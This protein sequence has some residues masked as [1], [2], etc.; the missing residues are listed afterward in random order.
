M[1]TQQDSSLTGTIFGS[2][3]AFPPFFF[4]PLPPSFPFAPLSPFGLPP[5]QRE[6]K[7]AVTHA[8][9]FIHRVTISSSTEFTQWVLVSGGKLTRW[10]V[11]S[12]TK[13][14][15]LSSYTET[16]IAKFTPISCGDIIHW[17]KTSKEDWLLI[18]APTHMHTLTSRTIILSPQ[19]QTLKLHTDFKTGHEVCIPPASHS[20]STFTVLNVD[21][22]ET[23]HLFPSQYY[24]RLK[25]ILTTRDTTEGLKSKS[26]SCALG[27]QGYRWSQLTFHSLNSGFLDTNHTHAADMI[28]SI[29]LLAIL[30]YLLQFE[31]K[32]ILTTTVV[33]A[34]NVIFEL[35]ILNHKR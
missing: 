4:L 9:Q 12:Y 28:S 7:I 23:N 8:L 6:R 17:T 31:V 26:K 24:L 14:F 19:Q 18:Q 32:A 2:E 13:W 1:R 21:F 22:L 11:L 10:V 20:G 5:A 34:T 27:H 15:V 3:S 29:Q 33:G 25:A 30:M 35:T 16:C